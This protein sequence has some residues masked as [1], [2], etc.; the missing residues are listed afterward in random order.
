[1]TVPLTPN[2]QAIL[3]LT[4]PLIVGRVREEAELL[5][6]GEY[7]RLAGLLREKQKQPADFLGAESDQ[8]ISV[9][10]NTLGRE[11][12][13]K[14]LNRGFQ[15]SQAIEHWSARSIWVMSRADP[16]YPRRLKS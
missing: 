1:M 3:L 12:I 4:A 13:E 8:I 7:N 9:A 15:L 2:T 11:R 14:L 6:P 5:T 16:E 10:A